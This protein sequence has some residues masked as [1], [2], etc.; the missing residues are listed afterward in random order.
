[1]KLRLSIALL[2]IISLSVLSTSYGTSP[3]SS[4]L[5]SSIQG[6]NW[7]L[8]FGRYNTSRAGYAALPVQVINVPGG[9][10]GPNEKFQIWVTK[11]KNNSSKAINAVK[12]NWYLFDSN[13]LNRLVQTEQT[14]L[15][16]LHLNPQAETEAEVL[17]TNLEDIPILRDK[18]PTGTFHLEVAAT[19]AHYEDGS[20][21]LAKDLPGN[22]D[23]GSNPRP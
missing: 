7:G 13:D 14:S 16:Q 9:K 19:E 8:S 11:L 20:V 5:D 10:R 2:A 22:L 17:I 4:S 6:R 12:F 3:T 18:N 1:M 23:L 15:Y 21:W